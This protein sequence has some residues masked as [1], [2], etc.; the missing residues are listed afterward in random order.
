[1][2]PASRAVLQF[3]A[4]IA[5]FYAFLMAPLKPTPSNMVVAGVFYTVGYLLFFGLRAFFL[6]RYRKL[7]EKQEEYKP[8]FNKG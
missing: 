2:N 4:S 8:R 7:S 6:K 3:A 1:M 5:S